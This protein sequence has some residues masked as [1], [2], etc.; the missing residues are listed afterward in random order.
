MT[1][2]VLL[3]WKTRDSGLSRTLELTDRDGNAANLTNAA[4]ITWVAQNVSTDAVDVEEVL[5]GDEIVDEAAGQIARN[6]D[7]A[8]D[9]AETGIWRIN[10]PVV[11][12]DGTRQTFPEDRYIYAVVRDSHATPAP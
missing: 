4:S 10:V 11:F 2:D 8:L 9:T 5:A 1:A 6:R 12:S 3:A 7:P